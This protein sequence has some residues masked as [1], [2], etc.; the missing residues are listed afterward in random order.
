MD[1]ELF[2]ILFYRCHDANLSSYRK[3]DQGLE[4]RQG[5][6]LDERK[7]IWKMLLLQEVVIM[8]PS[9]KRIPFLTRCAQQRPLL[10]GYFCLRSKHRN[11]IFFVLIYFYGWDSKEFKEPGGYISTPSTSVS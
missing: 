2:F 8:I 7:H 3:M 10:F 1:I 6:S 9:I 4:G 5:W 11:Q